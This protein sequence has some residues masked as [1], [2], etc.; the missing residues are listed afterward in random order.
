MGRRSPG[1]PDAR[2]VDDELRTALGQGRGP[3]GTCR[4]AP[5]GPAA[6]A[7]TA[8][9]RRSRSQPAQARG[10]GI[11]HGRQPVGRARG[12]VSAPERPPA[13]HGPSTRPRGSPNRHRRCP[14]VRR[15]LV[16]NPVSAPPRG[17]PPMPL[18]R[19]ARAPAGCAGVSPRARGPA[20]SRLSRGG[21]RSGSRGRVLRKS[22]G[23]QGIRVGG[24][25]AGAP[26]AGA[27]R[28]A[29]SATAD[30][31]LAQVHKWRGAMSR[32]HI[33]AHRAV[34]STCG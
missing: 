22:A 21:T 30:L 3:P 8:R 7:G 25:R 32:I 6:R 27:A 16:G 4:G 24:W 29:V 9:R 20:S 11:A 23:K 31:D 5:R 12:A 18:P 10:R 19:A 1:P 2:L 13:D 26:W 28:T 17:G 15:R 34:D 33:Q 14:Q